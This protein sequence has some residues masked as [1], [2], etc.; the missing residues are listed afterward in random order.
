V[1]FGG[2]CGVAVEV[3]VLHLEVA[4]EEMTYVGIDV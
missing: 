4:G 1:G 2:V 3:F